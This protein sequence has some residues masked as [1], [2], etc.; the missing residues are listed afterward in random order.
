MEKL[1]SRLK[2]GKPEAFRELLEEY[3]P[4][5]FSLIDRMIFDRT[6]REDLAQEIFIKVIENL[7]S[8]REDSKLSTWIYTITYRHLIDH[9]RR[10][11]H[12]PMEKTESLEPTMS[13]STQD[14]PEPLEG[15]R[16]AMLKILD[17][18]PE[19]YRIVITMRYLHERSIKDISRITDLPEGTVKVRI[20]R[21]L[22]LLRK[23]SH[24]MEISNEL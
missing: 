14:H 7:Q 17:A 20:H 4:M 8:F 11:R 21:G 10:T 22:R 2:N 12:D 24:L 1:E 9:L 19:K 16:N 6:I 3:S 18:I 23:K 5:V 13:L 15:Q